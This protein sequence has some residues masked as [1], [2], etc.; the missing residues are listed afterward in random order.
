MFVVPVN[1]LGAWMSVGCLVESVVV[2]GRLH[3]QIVPARLGLKGGWTKAD[4]AEESGLSAVLSMVVMW[5][6]SLV[7]AG[8][9]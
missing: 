5:A 6:A 2:N 1:P 4:G 9:L 3:P 7:S 8:G